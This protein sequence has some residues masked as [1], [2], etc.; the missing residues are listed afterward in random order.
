M[1]P[2][3]YPGPFSKEINLETSCLESCDIPQQ[4]NSKKWDY[5]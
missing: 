5:Y 3:K 1:Q 2:D 4:S